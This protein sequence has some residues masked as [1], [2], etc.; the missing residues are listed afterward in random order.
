MGRG[1]TTLRNHLHSPDSMAMIRAIKHFGAQI[2]LFS[3]RI[4]IEG[5]GGQLRAAEDII[6]AGNSGQILRFIGALAA[7]LPSYTVLTGDLSIRHRRPIQPL[8]DSLQRLGVFAKSTRLDGFAPIVIR[9]PLKGGET[10][11]EGEDSQPVSG[12]LIAASFADGPTEIQVKN[13]GE[14]PW[15]DLTLSWLE[16]LK[17]AYEREDYTYYRVQGGGGFEGFDYTVPGD[18]SSL[19][20]PLIAALISDS[21][22]TLGNVDMV[23]VQGDK[24]I[25]QILKGMGAK[26]T[27]DHK[28]KELHVKRGNRLRGI[29]IDIND[30][31]DA[32]TPLAV[33]GCYAEGKTEIRNGGI[34]R[35]KECDRIS[36]IAK[37][38]K[39]MGAYIQE[40]EDGLTIHSSPLKGA[41]VNTYHDHRMVMS[42]SVA[43]LGAQGETVVQEVSSISKTY[44]N[45][46]NHLQQLG[47]NLE[48]KG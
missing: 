35:K 9:G 42:L 10:E 21:T 33:L 16:Y 13:P 25:I 17:L 45:F 3:D 32:V 39:K 12:L 34:A 26:I 7:I 48:E 44:R 47:A 2:D 23:D 43:A 22:L 20:F 19:T 15:I 4:E 11:I 40:K 29:E 46:A 41:V 37:E 38:L 24:K 5:L 31:I 30:C 28:K 1:K 14:K 27:V 36:A 18:F 6:D 8:L